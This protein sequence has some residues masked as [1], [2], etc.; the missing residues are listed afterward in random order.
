MALAP[1]RLVLEDG[2]QGLWYFASAAVFVLTLAS[3]PLLYE[4][5]RRRRGALG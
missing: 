5:E 4:R 3:L 2:D 1:D